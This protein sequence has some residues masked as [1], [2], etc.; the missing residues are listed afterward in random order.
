MT[1]LLPLVLAQPSSKASWGYLKAPLGYLRVPLGYLRV[2]LG[3]LRAPLG[4]LRALIKHSQSGLIQ[5]EPLN[6]EIFKKF[7]R[8]MNLILFF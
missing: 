4:C 8:I 6:D 2:P 5:F 7:F 1:P 3:Y